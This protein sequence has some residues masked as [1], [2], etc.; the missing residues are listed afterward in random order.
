MPLITISQ[1]LQR[2]SERRIAPVYLLFGEEPYLIQEYATM[3]IEQI[4]G[5]AP[6]DFNCDVFSAGTRHLTGSASCRP[7]VA[8]ASVPPCGRFTRSAAAG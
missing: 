7:D 1:L 2:L 6:Y 5:T 3:L 8:Y 4:L